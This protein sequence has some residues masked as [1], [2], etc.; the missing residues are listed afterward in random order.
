MLLLG[1][2]VDFLVMAMN[3]L[4]EVHEDVHQYAV[5]RVLACP[6]CLLRHS[7]V[8]RPLIGIAPAGVVFTTGVVARD[9]INGRDVIEALSGR[10]SYCF[11]H[12]L[13][14]HSQ[15]GD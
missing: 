7:T 2:P 5:L 10:E 4:P 8:Y 6:I 9:S 15:T 1:L 12:S 13:P 14:F 11:T 3:R